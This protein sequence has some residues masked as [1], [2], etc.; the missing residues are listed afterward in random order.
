MELKG[1]GTDARIEGE[2]ISIKA[3]SRPGRLALGASDREIPLSKII[4]LDFTDASLLSNG[5]ISIQSDVGLS[6]IYFL[7][8]TTV[9]AREFFEA[10]K[11]GSLANLEL[12][13][14]GRFANE[15][16]QARIAARAVLQRE[17]DLK[18]VETRKGLTDSFVQ[19]RQQNTSIV[20]DVRKELAPSRSMSGS[21][22]DEE[23]STNELRR[24]LDAVEVEAITDA[25]ETIDAVSTE[26]VGADAAVDSSRGQS[27][28]DEADDSVSEAVPGETRTDAAT[29]LSVTPV[30]EMIREKLDA[31]EDA[32]SVGDIATEEKLILTARLYAQRMGKRVDR[33]ATEVSIN[34]REAKGNLR[35]GSIILGEIIAE[36]GFAQYS[37]KQSFLRVV[38]GERRILVRSDR[39][40]AGGLV[41]PVDEFT[42]AQVYL[43]GQELITQRPTLTRMLLLSPLPGSALIPGL[44]FQKK[45]TKD[46][47]Q[48]EFQIGGVGWSFRAAI[49]P[50][51]MSN[52]RQIAERINRVAEGLAEKPIR[53]EAP[54]PSTGEPSAETERTSELLLTQLERLAY[55]VEQGTLSVDEAVRIK[56]GI[57]K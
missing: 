56:G 18:W 55:L 35:I 43:D 14:A 17:L 12:V 25:S 31:A 10:I 38:A 22:T 32:A 47:R 8:R 19:W 6:V 21:I 54:W 33:H 20:N 48:G 53:N 49:A 41:R 11:H 5:R 46:T 39:I 29:S 52:P 15:H 28:A 9:P 2:S 27:G 16:N 13:P 36:S 23:A 30:D 24:L 4:A 3:K 51:S 1:Y 7:R 34:S 50:S 42:S 37:R 40:I 44:A 57:L 45:E 26:A